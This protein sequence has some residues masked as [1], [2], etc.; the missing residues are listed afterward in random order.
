MLGLG[1]VLRWAVTRPLQRLEQASAE[2]ARTGSLDH[3]VP[4]Q[5]PQEIARLARSFN[6]MA[7]Q[8]RDSR[9]ALDTSRARLRGIVEA[10]MDAVI[11]IDE[12]QRIIGA[13][14]AATRMFGAEDGTL[15]GRSI[16]DLIPVRARAGHAA[17]VRQFG[18][19]G[20]K[21]L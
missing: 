19:S 9:E 7:A 13:N 21:L 20:A 10:A 14:V 6:A 16:E 4:E 11:T 5:G 15:E 17:R 12:Q 2:L 8:I 18:A 1:F 3:P